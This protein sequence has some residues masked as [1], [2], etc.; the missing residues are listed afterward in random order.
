[1][2]QGE[3][4]KI[5]AYDPVAIPVARG[6]LK[7][8]AYCKD[9]YDTANGCDALVILTEWEEFKRLD[10]NKIKKLMKAPILIDGRNIFEP[11]KMKSLGFIYKSIGR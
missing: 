7:E 2:L 5:K 8:V 11:E 1:M 10:F 9:P 4:A 3:E 6:I